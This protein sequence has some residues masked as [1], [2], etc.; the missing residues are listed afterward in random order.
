[1]NTK[2]YLIIEDGIVI[3][4]DLKLRCSIIFHLKQIMIINLSY[5]NQASLRNYLDLLTVR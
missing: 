5:N 4:V 2:I 1:M 3:S